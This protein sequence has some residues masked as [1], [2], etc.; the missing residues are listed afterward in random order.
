[1]MLSS[2][3]PH[4]PKK[5]DHRLSFPLGQLR[6]RSTRNMGSEWRV[7]LERRNPLAKKLDLLMTDVRRDQT[8]GEAVCGVQYGNGSAPS[9]CPAQQDEQLQ[10]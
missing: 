9:A 3:C 7:A 6:A 2:K 1:M 5:L 10:E 8:H 4:V